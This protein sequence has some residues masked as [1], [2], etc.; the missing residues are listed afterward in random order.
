MDNSGSYFFDPS[1]LPGAEEHRAKLARERAESRRR[2]TDYLAAVLIGCDDVADPSDRAAV[3]LDALTVW[4]RADSDEPC[5]CGCHPRLPESD[6]H[7]YGFGCSCMKT[8]EERQRDL[9]D[10]AAARDAFWESP[11]G[12]AMM[13]AREAEEAELLAWLD[14]HPEVAVTC[15]GGVAPE[16]WEGSV[17]GHT[18]Y[19]RE[20]HDD[21]RIELDL[22]PSGQVAKRYLGG[23]L[24][25]E[26]SFELVEIERGDEIAEGTIRTHGYGE[27][28]VERVQFIV[29]TIRAH[30]ATQR[31]ALHAG[32]AR[33]DLAAL[34]G[35]SL[36]W[37]PACGL[38]LV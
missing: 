24:D 29:D 38:R 28:P 21:W 36:R 37:C 11:E 27:S 22:R 13:A 32:A 30:L 19:F 9:D 12:R 3:I 20:R 33:N 14:D 8:P 16:Q 1:G 35:R 4:R 25:D 26:S 10:W 15:H 34:L 17:D 23:D 18:F 31:C 6:F 5:R 2:Y 7:E